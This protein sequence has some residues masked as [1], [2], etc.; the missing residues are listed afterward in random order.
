LIQ[1]LRATVLRSLPYGDTSLI[2]RFLTAE[3]GVV[4]V[5]A[6]GVR[7]A[8]RKG[9]GSPQLFSSGS[10]TVQIRE[11]RDMHPLRDFAPDRV[12]L[13]L[14]SSLVRLAGAS[15]LADLI[16]RHSGHEAQ[17]DLTDQ[18][19]AGLDAIEAVPEEQLGTAVL[20]RAWG[21]VTTLGYQPHLDNCVACGRAFEEK[22]IGR[23]DLA[24]GGVAC[25]DC[26]R[27]GPRLGPIAR[28][29]MR[30]LIAYGTAGQQLIAA[31]HGDRGRAGLPSISLP[32]T[33]LRI[34]ADF[35]SYHVADGRRIASFDYFLET[36]APPA[37]I[38]S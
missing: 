21:I 24:R 27:E 20:C 17:A 32:A 14:A 11:N 38:E 22:E 34:L 7:G 29:E 2:I 26:S 31:E 19:E 37:R 30:R 28:E 4:T 10:L 36:L 12:R 3:S 6:R 18:M 9:G 35:A 15:L 13:G 1:S 5:M 16:L 23:F 25:H 8:R 33:H